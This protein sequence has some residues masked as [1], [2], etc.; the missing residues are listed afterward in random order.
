MSATDC[1]ATPLTGIT[2]LA[3]DGQVTLARTSEATMLAWGANLDGMLGNGTTTDSL[4]PA[5]V[6]SSDGSGPLTGV[7]AIAVGRRHRLAI[8]AGS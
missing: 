7:A 1:T 5:T 3:V 4:A 8:R 2:T 6:L